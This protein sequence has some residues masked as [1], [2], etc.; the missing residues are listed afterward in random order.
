MLK[1]LTLI[2]IILTFTIKVFAF[3]IIRICEK[4]NDITI[5]WNVVND[6]CQKFNKYEIY[7][8]ESATDNFK[9]IDENKSY[10]NNEYVHIGAGTVSNNWEYFI[11]AIIQ[12]GNQK[13]IYSDTLNI[14]K[15]PPKKIN[16]DS[17]SVKNG[18]VIIGWEKS[19]DKDTKG[20]IVY[21]VNGAMNIIIDTL[22]GN[23][24]TYFTDKA[25]RDPRNQTFVY[26]VVA[27]DS[28]ENLSIF[29]DKH[30]NIKLNISQNFCSKTVSLNW[31]RYIAWDIDS[32]NYE[33]LVKIEGKNKFKILYTVAG[34]VQDIVINN[35]E[36]DTNYVFKIRARNLNNNFTSSSNELEIKTNFINTPESIYLRNVSVKSDNEIEI[37]WEIRQKG[38]I[39]KFNIYRGI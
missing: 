22:I 8:R 35:L 30:N 23:T 16:I 38:D 27:M 25:I 31:N 21:Y 29:S 6:T 33:I 19:K 36:N 28:C 10:F 34:S 37:K 24:N 12:C 17:V 13:M 18:R 1:K 3:N 9:K 11:V 5:I 7:G 39:K 26:K 2:I 14:D 32:I 20:Y 15:N 4:E